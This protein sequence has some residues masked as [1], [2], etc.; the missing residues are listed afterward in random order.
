MSC[1]LV[2]HLGRGLIVLGALLIPLITLPTVGAARGPAFAADELLVGFNAGLSEADEEHVYKKHG[3]GKI[4]K[5]RGPNVHR[6]RVPAT[7]LDEVKRKLQRDPAVKFVELNEMVAPVG[8]PSGRIDRDRPSQG[9]R[10]DHR[11]ARMVS[12]GRRGGRDAVDALDRQP[13]P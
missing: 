3:G 11:G 7:S 13:R 2:R 1:A 12:R 10:Q 9:R 4:E 5:L 8:A 6:I